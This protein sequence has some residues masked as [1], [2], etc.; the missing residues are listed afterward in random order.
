MGGKAGHPRSFR[1]LYPTRPEIALRE[2]PK[3]SD[4]ALAEMCGV[5]H[6]TVNVARP[7]S[8]VGKLPTST[9]EGI[10]GKQY[11]ATRKPTIAIIVCLSTSI[12]LSQ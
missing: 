12:C 4:R 2:F 11:P 9:R 7:E 10:D 1:C 8:K 6:H 5:S 3:M